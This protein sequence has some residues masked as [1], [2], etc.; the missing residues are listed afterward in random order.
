MR[1]KPGGHPDTLTGGKYFK[2]YVLWL[3]FPPMLL[4]IILG[5]QQLYSALAP[6]WGGGS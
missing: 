4:F 1:N 5:I 2:F 6:L 3:T